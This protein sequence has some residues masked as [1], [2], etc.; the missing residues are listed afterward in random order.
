MN[1]SL[2][3]PAEVAEVLWVMLQ[4]T[5]VTILSGNDNGGNDLELQSR[6]PLV[7]EALARTETLFTTANNSVAAQAMEGSDRR[8][9]WLQMKQEGRCTVCH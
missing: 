1:D 2:L 7:A 5:A 4:V 3:I 9:R 8:D 6:N